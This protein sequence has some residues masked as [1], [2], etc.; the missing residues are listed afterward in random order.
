MMH[1][2]EIEGCSPAPLAHYLKALGILRLVSE[3]ADTG[4]RG[5]WQGERFRLATRLDRAAVLDFFVR[6]YEPTPLVA[7]WNKGS[8]FFA[9]DDAGVT[10][11]ERSTE[12]RF[13]KFR[14]AIADARKLLHELMRADALARS[15][16]DEVKRKDLTRAQRDALRESAEYKQRL[17][18]AEKTFK[19]L[20]SD[21]L[22]RC[23]VT[24]RGPHLEWMNAALVLAPDAPPLFPALFGTGGNDGRLDF[25]NNFMQ[26][27]AELFLSNR[28]R[29]ARRAD[30]VAFFESALWGVVARTGQTGR[31]VG[32]YLP[33]GAGGANSTTGAEGESWLNP[34]DFILMLEGA[35]LFT[36]HASRRLGTGGSVRAAAPFAVDAQSAGYSSAANADEGP[37]GEQWMPLWTQPVSLGELRR[38]LS[39]GRAQLGTRIAREPLDLAKALARMGSARGIS[40]FQRYG[41]I[42]RNGQSN[43]AVPLGRFRVPDG[44]MPTLAC[45]DD[46]DRWFSH[47]LRRVARDHAPARLKQV[48]RQLGDAQFA[49]VQ[50]PE[51]H[52]RW[53]DV[54][55]ALADVE[56]VLRTGSGHEAQPVPLLRPEWVAAAND[57]S[58][59]FRLAL[60]CALQVDSSSRRGSKLPDGVRRHWIPLDRH[61]PQ[62]FAT[63]SS[64][65]QRDPGVVLE[66]RCGVEDAIALVLRRLVE[67]GRGDERA[68][69]LCATARAAAHQSDLAL[70]ISERLDVNRAMHLARA[71]MAVDI[72]EWQR[73]TIEVSRPAFSGF[74][75]DAWM[76]IRLALLPWPLFGERQIGADPAIVRRLAAG[77]AAPA[78]DLALRRLRAADIRAGIRVGT[79]PQKVARLWAAALAF[80]ITQS[81]ARAFARRLDPHAQSGEQS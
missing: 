4:A 18:A 77:D 49:V 41:Y 5:W 50:R 22:P 79:V 31:A 45:L 62:R 63:T 20:K 69:P 40:A 68:L 73:S 25:T 1:V 12:E 57:K 14:R 70:F 16:K 32:Q 37:R 11:I 6:T 34:A 46:I 67:G 64:G 58:P 33:G 17:A 39:E 43:L 15:I 61:K 19:T 7:P 9:A 10:P 53:Q 54:L 66:G 56:H 13:A 51:D 26:R 78:V 24:W 48:V 21:L 52:D 55:I 65:L 71:L 74:P 44:N 60:A 59:E 75:T 47:G 23:R 3:Q 28:D 76:A 42:E 35:I 36:A 72:R 30:P 38:M 29:D 80:P 27:L 2:H 8:G 81:T